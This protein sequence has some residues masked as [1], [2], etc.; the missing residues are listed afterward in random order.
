MPNYLHHGSHQYNGM[1][2]RDCKIFFTSLAIANIY[3]TVAAYMGV[4]LVEWVWR[5]VAGTMHRP[6]SVWRNNDKALQET[7]L[8]GLC[9]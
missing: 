5:A 6:V 7:S 1:S 9:Q 3:W 4:S 8:E 2:H